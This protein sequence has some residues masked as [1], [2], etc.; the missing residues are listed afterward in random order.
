[1]GIVFLLAFLHKKNKQNELESLE[2]YNNNP[3]TLMQV[4]EFDT[5]TQ[6][7]SFL[8]GQYLSIASINENLDTY[9]WATSKVQ[10]K[11]FK[12]AEGYATV[13]I[14]SCDANSGTTNMS[15]KAVNPQIINEFIT[16]LMNQDM[17]HNVSYSGYNYTSENLYQ[18]N[19]S[20][21]L[22]EAVGRSG[23]E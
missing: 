2:E 18:V 6:R 7:N 12:L 15:V 10:K 9:P 8:V 1:M 14:T 20:C 16:I 11:I 13:T 4:E 19:V 5:L 3:A 17:F 23:E 21:T 22:E